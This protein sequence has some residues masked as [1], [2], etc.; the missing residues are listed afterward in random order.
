MA[1]KFQLRTRHQFAGLIDKRDRWARMKDQAG[2]RARFEQLTGPEWARQ[3]C[4]LDEICDPALWRAE[5]LDSSRVLQLQCHIAATQTLMRF[6]DEKEFLAGE[7]LLELHRVMLSGG[8]E[9]A[10]EY[11]RQG[12]RALAE[13]HEPTD[14]ELVAPVV[15]NALGWFQSDSFAEMH[16][17]EK[18]ALMLIKLIDVQPFDEAN[19]R[20]LRLFSNFFLL[21]AGYPPAVIPACK[22]S[23]YAIAIQNSLRF[24]TQPII[25][26]I[27][28]AADQ[29]LRCCLG[30]PPAP[31][32]LNVLPG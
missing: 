4:A 6:A 23:Q 7:D 18:S 25:D 3:N 12:V 13:G 28:E 17:V 15:E 32:K 14:V 2:A 21:K 5:V 31:P 22:A 20:T 26:L 10:G 29:S 30:E 11:R 27:A 19:G 8:H 16:E 24:H 9:T 1:E